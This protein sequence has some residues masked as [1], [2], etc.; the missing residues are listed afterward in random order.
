[1]PDPT[2][3]WIAGGQWQCPA[4]GAVNAPD[5]ERCAGCGGSVRPSFGEP[6]RP[7]DPADIIGP[8]KTRDRD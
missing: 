1:M 8:G 2:G 3:R 7:P 4:C 6:I 5:R